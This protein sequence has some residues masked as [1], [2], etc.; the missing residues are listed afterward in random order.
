MIIDENKLLQQYESHLIEMA[1]LAKSFILS[2]VSSFNKIEIKDD[3]SPVT[4]VDRGCELLL[5]DYIQKTF[6]DHG[7]IGE[8]FDNINE[9][10]NFTW[11][12]DPIDGT[13]SF[14]AAVPLYGTLIALNYRKKPIL[15]L[16]MQPVLNQLCIGNNLEAYSFDVNFRNKKRIMVRKLKSFDKALVLTTDVKDIQKYQ[17]WD[18]FQSLLDK[19]WLFRTWGDCYGYSMVANSNADFML[20]PIMSPW[21]I[22]AIIPI[23]Q[24]AGGAVTGWKGE[25]AHEAKSLIACHIDWHEKLLKEIN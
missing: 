11:V 21:D 22:M 23:I 13:K 14:I 10:A 5:R 25:L 12:L 1:K 8:E 3:A 19:T 6:P 24:G 9:D 7:I 15:G 17:N 2:K 16:L 4:E 18:K 20:D